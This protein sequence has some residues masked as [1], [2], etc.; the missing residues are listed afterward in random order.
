[1]P[2]RGSKLGSNPPRLAARAMP[3]WRPKMGTR[4]DCAE[5]DHP[6]GC[7][8]ARDLPAISTR[9]RPLALAWYSAVSAA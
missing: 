8:A 4:R 2:R 6:H 7:P 1:M 5:S 9:F 3:E